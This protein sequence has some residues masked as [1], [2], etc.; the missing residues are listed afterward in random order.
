[1]TTNATMGKGGK[2]PIC[3]VG[4]MQT[5]VVNTEVSVEAFQKS[6]I[7][8]QSHPYLLLLNIC[9]RNLCPTIEVNSCSYLMLYY[10]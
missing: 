10:T 8:L 4:G 6:K 1:M 3:T 5:Y 2:Q 9:S 7:D